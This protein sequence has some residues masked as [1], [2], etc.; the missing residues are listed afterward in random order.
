MKPEFTEETYT[1]EEIR[2]AVKRYFD[3]MSH[4][5]TKSYTAYMTYCLTRQYRHLSRASV[6]KLADSV[7][8]SEQRHDF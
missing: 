2:E 4:N 7:A 8:E 3:F 1:P 5:P 6:M